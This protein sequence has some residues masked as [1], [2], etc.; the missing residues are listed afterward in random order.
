M[1]VEARGPAGQA[2]GGATGK[3]I[4]VIG[5]V[6]DVEFPPD[7][8]PE[9]NYALKFDR[10]VDGKPQTLTAEVAQHIGDRV[11]RAI[12]MQPTDG[13][14]RGTQVSNTGAPI[15]DIE[16][17]AACFLVISSDVPGIGSRTVEL[18]DR[19]CK[20]SWGSA[21]WGTGVIA[22]VSSMAKYPEFLDLR[23]QISRHAEQRELRNFKIESHIVVRLKFRDLLDREKTAYQR[24]VGLAPGYA[25]PDAEGTR[26]FHIWET[27]PRFN[28][29][30]TTP[31]RVLT[32]FLKHAAS[33]RDTHT[34]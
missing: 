13:V 2:M 24:A 25:I 11:V 27:A 31:E 9:I 5:P 4:Q 7:Q 17:N 30:N 16:F 21:P 28:T 18:P 23:S 10:V 14:A 6:V 1:A 20:G 8:L 34:K 3:V 12:V 22:D 15:Y 33:P 26:L 29:S 32:S 19:S